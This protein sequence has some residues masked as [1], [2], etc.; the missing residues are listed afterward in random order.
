MSPQ[1]QAMSAFYLVGYI[2][3]YLQEQAAQNVNQS[4]LQIH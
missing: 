2:Q 1:K 3:T 4:F